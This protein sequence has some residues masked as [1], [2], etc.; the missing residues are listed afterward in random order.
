[1]PRG[2]TAEQES[3]ERLSD[4]QLWSVVRVGVIAAAL[5]AVGPVYYVLVSVAPPLGALI[6]AAVPLGAMTGGLFVVFPGMFVY[7]QSLD[8]ADGVDEPAY[9]VNDR[10]ERENL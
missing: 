6:P 4:S 1:M 10:W 8:P 7:A 5:A 3:G 9:G 2:S